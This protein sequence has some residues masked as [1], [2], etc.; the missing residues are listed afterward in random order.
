M[1]AGGLGK[2]LN[3]GGPLGARS[4]ALILGI[5]RGLRCSGARRGGLGV[6]AERRTRL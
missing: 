6:N 2:S 1:A 4:E 5:V 3:I